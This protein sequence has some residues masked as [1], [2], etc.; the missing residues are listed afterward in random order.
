MKSDNTINNKLNKESY[1]SKQIK[2]YH[3]IKDLVM[4]KMTKSNF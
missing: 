3:F 2:K 4:H 1:L